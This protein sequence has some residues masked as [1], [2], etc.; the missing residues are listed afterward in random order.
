MFQWPARHTLNTGQNA[1]VFEETLRSPG[2]RPA[3]SATAAVGSRG[4]MP[5][6]EMR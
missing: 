6:Q 5:E 2:S 4:A 1:E 3:V